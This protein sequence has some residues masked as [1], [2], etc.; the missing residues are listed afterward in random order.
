M[1][2]CSICSQ[3]LD[4]N[5]TSVALVYGAGEIEPGQ[6][7]PQG[8]IVEDVCPDCLAADRLRLR[9]ARLREYAG[10]LDAL[11]LQVQ[12]MHPDNWLTPGELEAETV[13]N[14]P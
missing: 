11:A 1:V 2:E 6:N 8:T 4:A 13:A 9:A 10:E 12:D 3:G 14:L 5:Y 7:I